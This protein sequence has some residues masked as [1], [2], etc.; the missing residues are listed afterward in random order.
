MNQVP[1]LCGV[2]Q[3]DTFTMDEDMDV[4]IKFPKEALR[5]RQF[6]MHQVFNARVC[7]NPHGWND[8]V[9]KIAGERTRKVKRALYDENVQ[10]FWQKRGWVD[11]V[12]AR[13]FAEKFVEHKK[14]KHGENIWVLLF[15]DNL[16]A[17]L[18]DQMKKNVW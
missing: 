1:L 13:D 12:V 18:D 15:C 4:N 11:K 7:N 6:T 14:G 16:S 3:D 9:C 2:S 17:H 10:V 8:L 5:K